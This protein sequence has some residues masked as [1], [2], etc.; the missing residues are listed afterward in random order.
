[1]TNNRRYKYWATGPNTT[2]FESYDHGYS[3]QH[4]TSL[5]MYRINHKKGVPLFLM[6]YNP[7]LEAL[8][9]Q[10]TGYLKRRYKS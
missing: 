6:G 4:N 10:L 7:H 1:M 2:T 5:D 9:D 3:I 8:R